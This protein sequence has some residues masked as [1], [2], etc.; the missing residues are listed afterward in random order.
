MLLNLDN[1]V[2]FKRA[3][4]RRK[5]FK[6]FVKDI[7]GID[8][9]VGKIDTEKRF[10]PKIGFIN[11]KY[12]IYAETIDK[13]IIIEIQKVDYDYNLDRFLL[14]HNMALA[15]Q[16]KNSRE[17]KIEKTV[18]TIVVITEPY[19]VRDKNGMLLK[20]DI[21]VHKTNFFTDDGIELPLFNHKLICLN[22]NY[23]TAKTPVPVRDWLN[24]IYESIHHPKNYQVN[25]KNEGIRETVNTIIEDNIGVEI[26]T[27]GKNREA[28]KSAR[29]VYDAEIKR[30]IATKMKVDGCN[31]EI[32]AKYTELSL[33]EIEKL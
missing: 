23:I 20:N 1:E 7:L 30:E 11:F 28:A 29:K 2:Y 22:P 10:S 33:E 24:L 6:C 12:D 3:F 14:Y 9:E 31:L 32:I 5:I 18:Y 27:L 15:E 13:R 17:Y 19:V 8:V 4:T 25:L 26:R 16:R 21:L